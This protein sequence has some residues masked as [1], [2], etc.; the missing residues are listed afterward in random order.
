MVSVPPRSGSEANAAV[1]GW[2]RSA[3]QPLPLGVLE[4]LRAPGVAGAQVAHVV[5]AVDVVIAR[6]RPGGPP[7]FHRV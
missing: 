1:L 2:P 3:V 6:P 4:F 7:P 5:V